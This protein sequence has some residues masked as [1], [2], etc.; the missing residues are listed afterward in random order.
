MLTKLAKTSVPIDPLI[1]KRWSPRSLDPK[2]D[3]TP[4]QL[5]ALLE[6]AR[7]APS[8][9]GEEPWRYVVC[10]KSTNPQAW[11]LA[12]SCLVEFNQNWVK[13][14]PLILLST[15]HD[16]FKRNNEPNHWAQHD[17]GAASENLCLQAASMGLVAHQMGGFDA[18]KARKVFH[19]P[20]TYTC[21]AMIAV[22][23]QADP[24]L[25]SDELKTK[26]LSERKRNA[27]SVNFFNGAWGKG[28]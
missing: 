5:T 28:V 3:I 25:L 22:G 7:W 24:A 6:A 15:C 27:L 1:E 17:T 11:A 19:V 20:S 23:Y 12:F 2:K 26:E 10:H 14:A 16:Y 13:N 18:Q 4:T 9:S 21:L 8:C